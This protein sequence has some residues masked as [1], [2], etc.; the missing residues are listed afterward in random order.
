MRAHGV[1]LH[2]GEPKMRGF[3]GGLRFRRRAVSI[4]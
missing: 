2:H 1:G 3:A 4:R